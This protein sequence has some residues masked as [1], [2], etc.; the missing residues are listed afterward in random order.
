[1]TNSTKKRSL[2]D[3]LEHKANIYKK[4][5]QQRAKQ[6]QQ[7]KELKDFNANPKIQ[8]LIFREHFPT[9]IRPRDD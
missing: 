7:Q 8:E 1:M 9:K 2:T 3:R 5:E 4:Q 6:V